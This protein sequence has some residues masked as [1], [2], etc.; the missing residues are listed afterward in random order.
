MVGLHRAILE[1]TVLVVLEVAGV[2]TNGDGPL[3]QCLRQRLAIS[4]RNFGVAGYLET[5]LIYLAGTTFFAS[6]RVSRL[7]GDPLILDVVE[8]VHHVTSSAAEVAVTLR[9]I[10]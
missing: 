9:T 2:D 1:G 4:F 3:D 10:H 6:I 8:G 7:S 5:P